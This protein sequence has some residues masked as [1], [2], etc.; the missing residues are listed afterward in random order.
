VTSAKSTTQTRNSPLIGFSNLK[1]NKLSTS[2]LKLALKFTFV[3]DSSEEISTDIIPHHDYYGI[4]KLQNLIIIP[5]TLEMT[6]TK[7]NAE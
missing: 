7:I 6:S 5:T 3:N 2:K 1:I 4:K